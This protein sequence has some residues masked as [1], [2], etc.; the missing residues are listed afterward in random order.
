MN[1]S[2]KSLKDYK[3]L[4]TKYLALKPKYSNYFFQ[5]LNQ[6]LFFSTEKSLLFSLND[7]SINRI[8]FISSD[9]EELRNILF[10][11]K[12]GIVIN[13][14]TKGDISFWR[15]LFT[16][17]GFILNATYERFYYDSNHTDDR[18][19]CEFADYSTKVWILDRL[20]LYF[21]PVNDR[22]PSEPELNSMI[23]NNQVLINR[24]Y[25]NIAGF[26]IFSIQGKKCYLNCWYDESGN[27]I[28]LINNIFALMMTKEIN[29]IY[30]WVNSLNQKVQKLHKIL[31]AKSDGLKDYTF[32]K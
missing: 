7:N 22:I 24:V 17:C 5:D 28:Y 20:S 21:N 8:Y 6:A 27:G 25:N 15:D 9:L 1:V 26:M 19:S 12:S 10:S 23:T 14:P 18:F 2:F 3:S 31:G 29:Y 11:L 4:L 16:D 13:I 32:L 30:F